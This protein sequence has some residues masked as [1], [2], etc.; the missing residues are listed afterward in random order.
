M[1]ELMRLKIPHNWKVTDNKFYDVDP[2]FDNDGH[3]INWHEGFCEDV[4]WIQESKFTDGKYLSPDTNCI[5]IDI[6]YLSG[7]YVAKHKYTSKTS[8]SVID[9]LESTDRI[10]IRDKI[11]TWLMDINENYKTFKEKMMTLYPD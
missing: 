9:I 8:S 6:S 11:E 3:I 1:A 4:L 2:I 10:K 7:Q 5:D